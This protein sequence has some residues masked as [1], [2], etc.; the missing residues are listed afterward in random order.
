MEENVRDFYELLKT[1]SEQVTEWMTFLKDMKSNIDGEDG[2]NCTSRSISD[3]FHGMLRSISRQSAYQPQPKAISQTRRSYIVDRDVIDRVASI[4]E[5]TKSKVKILERN[6]TDVLKSMQD[7]FKNKSEPEREVPDREEA[8]L[9]VVQVY[10]HGDY[11]GDIVSSLTDTLQDQFVLAKI[12]SLADIDK[13]KPLLILCQS[14]SRLQ[15]DLK[16]ALEEFDTLDDLHASIVVVHSKEEHALPK[17]SSQLQVTGEERYKSVSLI[18][19]A[20]TSESKFYQCNM[21]SEA[22]KRLKKFVT[23]TEATPD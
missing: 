6:V 12:H 13:S 8:P 9:P 23:S 10:D 5:D 18:D 11:A 20:F 3:R 15:P 4:I 22:L 2:C 21:N 14:T 17:T 16:Y 1:H 19:V 7:Y